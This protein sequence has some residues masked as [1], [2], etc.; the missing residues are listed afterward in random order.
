MTQELPGRLEIDDRGAVLVVTVDGGPHALFGRD[1]ANQL[2]ELVRR[3]DGEPDVRAVV[4]TGAHPDRFVSHAEVRW[5]QEGGAAV[6]PVGVRGASAMART[7]RGANRAGA[8]QPLVRRT[9]L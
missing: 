5:L 9:P 1:I 6:P 4:F 2:D 8:L 7:A 3:A